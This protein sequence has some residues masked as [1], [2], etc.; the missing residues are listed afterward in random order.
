MK[1][2]MTMRRSSLDRWGTWLL[3]LLLIVCVSMPAFSQEQEKKAE[4]KKD[5]KK[6]EKKK[7]K[8]LPLEPTRKIEFTTDE[9]TWLSLDVSPDGQTIIFELLGDLYTLP[10]E[11]G[12][13][14]R[15]TEGMAFDSQPRFSPD[16][17]WI[18]F[19]SDR[20]GS[21]NIWLVKPDGK[22]PKKL[23]KDSGRIHFASP[24]W[25]SD[26]DYVIASRTSWGL[27]T[28]ELWM[29][30]I[31]GGKGVQITKAK[32]D[33]NTPNS[34]RH[35]A[36]GAVMSPDG[37]Y[38]YYARKRG[39]FQYNAVF[40]LWQIAR[41]DMRTGNEDVIT[42]ELGSAIRPILS[43][44]G[45]Q[46]VYGT[47]YET[48]TGLRIRNLQTGQ[49]RWLIYPIQRD[50]QEAIFSRDLLPSY[51]F[52]PDGKELLVTSGGKIQRV[53]VASGQAREIPF[54]AQVSVEL[55]PQ[56]NFPRRV[57]DGP[58]R[59]RLIQGAT[60]SPDGKRI[61]FSTLAHLYTMELPGGTPKRLTTGN[62]REFQPA[63]SPDGRWIAFV[64]W[65]TGGG[66]LW[67]T[68]SD[69]SGQPQKIN[70]VAAYYSDPA[71][72]PDGSKIIIRRGSGY[73]RTQTGGGSLDLVWFPSNGGEPN[74][75]IPARDLGK[76]H[77]GPEEDRIY[78]YAATPFGFGPGQGLVSMRYDGTDRRT[79]IRVTGAGLYS[80][81]KPVGAND[82]RISPDGRWALAHVQN[83]LYILAVP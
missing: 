30:H 25:S 83:Q 64:T 65:E 43:P 71:F 5:E 79:H 3:A 32:R 24:L 75:I 21:E 55:G 67:K 11:G 7:K 13:A 34:Q 59:A 56:L 19:V 2:E 12:D 68:R 46:L 27:R 72:S 1:G 29:Y 10:I 58:V 48:Q 14:T 61:V 74:L 44:D 69:G 63:W 53:S 47:R 23:S 41:R 77:F 31:K 57:E 81:E 62:Q 35:N 37:R 18:A 22:D 78:L 60:Q 51:A 4:D 28:Y 73:M 6:E 45:S 36:I 80:A 76:P 38:L 70:N 20:S 49:D 16:G 42:R 9:A 40:P 54:S 52:M 8:D 15:I 50:D 39:G 33:S 26:G 82:I 17:K 66:Y